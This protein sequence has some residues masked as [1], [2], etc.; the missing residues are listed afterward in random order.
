M[1]YELDPIPATLLCENLDTLLQTIRNNINASLT[2]GIV[3]CIL[4][5]AI[6][7]RLLKNR[8][9]RKNRPKNYRPISNLLFMS[10]I[11]MILQWKIFP[12]QILFILLKLKGSVTGAGIIPLT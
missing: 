1:S 9:L 8:H 3:P 2:T 12:A 4:K 5:T 7:K 11:R 10:R 6:V